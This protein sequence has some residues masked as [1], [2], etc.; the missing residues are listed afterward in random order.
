[1]NKNYFIYVEGIYH[2]FTWG[3]VLKQLNYSILMLPISIRY[4]DYIV[5][6]MEQAGNNT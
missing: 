1:M 2:R 4:I 3:V 6:V 5:N